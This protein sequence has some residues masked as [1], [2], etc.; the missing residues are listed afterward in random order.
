MRSLITLRLLT[1]AP[2]GAPVAAPTTSIPAPPGSDQ[3]WD[4]RFSWPRDA[5]IGV[6]AFLA[7]GSAEEPQ[8]FLQWFINAS[9]VTRPRLHVLYDLDGQRASDERTVDAVDGYRGGRPVRVG[10]GAAGQHQLDVYGWVLDAA[11]QL[12]CAGYPLERPE[13]RALRSFADFIADHWHEP[14]SGIWEER[15]APRQFVHSKLMALAGLDRAL[16]LSASYPAGT[17]PSRWHAARN[18]MSREIVSRGFDERL[19]SFTRTFDSDDLDAA[20]LSIAAFD[21]CDTDRMSS[22]LDA[23]RARLGAGG[24]LL[25]RTLRHGRPVEAAFAPC[26]FWLVA[27]LA[28]MG[29]LAEAEQTF[30]ELCLLSTPLGLYAEQIDPSTNEHVGNFPQAFTHATLVQAAAA[31]NE[32]RRTLQ[33]SARTARA[34]R[35]RRAAS[36]TRS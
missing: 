2:S 31:L 28:R 11:W 14:D 1:Y 8:A 21:V 30:D 22:T 10:N 16:R 12:H 32:A 24:P 29:R 25:Y 27:A 15:E 17:R 5:S 23:V 7:F 34:P 35:S 19:R 33:E 20:V 18:A 4:Y 3:T 6:D 9:R 13:W 36:A 26:S